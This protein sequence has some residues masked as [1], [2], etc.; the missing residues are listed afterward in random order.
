MR[1]AIISFFPA[2]IGAYVVGSIIST[3]VILAKVEAMGMPVMFRDRLRAT[4]HDLLGLATSYLPLMV[5]AFLLALPVAAGLSR[6]MPQLRVYLLGLA[7]F[8]AI[9][10][11]HLIMK[12]VLGL[13]GIASVREIHGLL[14]QGLAGWCGGYLFSVFTGPAP[15]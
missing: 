8:V 2:V 14:L 12:A 9:L 7:G 6:R 10:A 1:R 5:L 15:R 3:Q 13:N 4:G 11:L